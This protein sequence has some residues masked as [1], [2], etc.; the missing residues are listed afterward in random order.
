M[1]IRKLITASAVGKLV[2][3]M[4]IVFIFFRVSRL[5]QI[6]TIS[7]CQDFLL[8][9]APKARGDW[10][11]I[12]P[13]SNFRPADPGKGITCFDLCVPAGNHSDFHP[14]LRCCF[15]RLINLFNLFS[16]GKRFLIFFPSPIPPKKAKNAPTNEKPTFTNNSPTRMAILYLFGSAHL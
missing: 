3:S 8:I 13:S 4:R 1:S 2:S 11:K 9:A 10:F 7:S 6:V 15:H 12:A 14:R 16:K 5:T